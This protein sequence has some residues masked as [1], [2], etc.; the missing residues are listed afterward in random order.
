MCDPE[1]ETTPQT[2]AGTAQGLG[3]TDQPRRC[4]D[5]G[6]AIPASRL[7]ANPHAGRCLDCQEEYELLEREG[8]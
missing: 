2:L 4:A 3:L 8:L 6:E 7:V 5:C 1:I